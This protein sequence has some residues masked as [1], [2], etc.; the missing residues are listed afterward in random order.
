MQIW[1]RGTRSYLAGIPL[2]A[3]RPSLA[4]ALRL[5][6]ADA[7]GIPARQAREERTRPSTEPGLEE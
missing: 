4:A 7:G 1:P 2:E 5:L 3:F 6:A